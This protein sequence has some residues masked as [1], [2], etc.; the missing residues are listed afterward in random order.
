MPEDKEND[1]SDND[2]DVEEESLDIDEIEAAEKY[3]SKPSV[4]ISL[5][6]VP[7]ITPKFAKTLMKIGVN[8]KMLAS[9]EPKKLA[10]RVKRMGGSGIKEATATKLITNA[11]KVIG[12]TTKSALEIKLLNDLMDEERNTITTGS[13][14][15]DRL[16]SR[17]NR[18]YRLDSTY[19]LF[20]PGAAGKTELAMQAVV[21]IFL[22]SDKGGLIR[23]G[24]IPQALIINT[25]AGK[26]ISRL[27]DMAQYLGISEKIIDKNVFVRDCASSEEQESAALQEYQKMATGERNYVLVIVD[28]LVHNFRLDYSD[29]LS[30]LAPRQ[31][32]LNRHIKILKDIIEIS[33]TPDGLPGILICTNQIMH[34]PIMFGDPMTH[35]GGNVVAHNLDI[36]LKITPKGSGNLRKSKLVDSSDL[37]AGEALFTINNRGICGADGFSSGML[38]LGLTKEPETAK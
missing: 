19:E 36:R 22:P 15:L 7:G 27:F 8:L 29:S 2:S 17:S 16:I 35:I 37:P 33:R 26:S 10:S 18:G 25:E 20:G 1:T 13:E 4:H 12:E 11:K 28:S 5:D 31:R 38:K 32:A 23:D 30:N 34:R 3:L 21:N 14:D 24:F 6:K 9:M